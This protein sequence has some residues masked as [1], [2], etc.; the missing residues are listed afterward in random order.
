MYILNHNK[1][2]HLLSLVMSEYL[3]IYSKVMSG[4]FQ[5]V[6]AVKEKP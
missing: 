2:G 3:K 1:K 5:Y 4:S 6:Y